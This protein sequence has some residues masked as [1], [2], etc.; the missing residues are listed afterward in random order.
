MKPEQS[1]HSDVLNS[2][3]MLRG[4]Q[5]ARILLLVSALGLP[6]CGKTVTHNTPDSAPPEGVALVMPPAYQE[7]QKGRVRAKFAADFAKGLELNKG[8]DHFFL[9]YDYQW[10][11]EEAMKK[12]GQGGDIP[13]AIFRQTDNA[14]LA[15]ALQRLFDQWVHYDFPKTNQR[16]YRGPYV[17]QLYRHYRFLRYLEIL[18]EQPEKKGAGDLDKLIRGWFE[19]DQKAWQLV[20]NSPFFGIRQDPNSAGPL[21]K[22]LM[23]LAD[24][25]ITE[26]TGACPNHASDEF[27]AYYWTKIQFSVLDMYLPGL[28]RESIRDRLRRAGLTEDD[29]GF[30]AKGFESELKEAFLA[31]GQFFGR[32]GQIAGNLME[33]RIYDLI[34]EKFKEFG[35]MEH[36]IDLYRHD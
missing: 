34:S 22:P 16:L 8:S 9:P 10:K 24:K 15:Q 17:Q 32:S 30:D 21:E 7:L 1:G 14:V 2:D 12:E 18:P 4:A 27:K 26:L 6:A 5:R 3:G 33:R 31:R 20:N 13:D 29:W 35:K 11:L 25:L 36:P 28:Y 23:P 19:R